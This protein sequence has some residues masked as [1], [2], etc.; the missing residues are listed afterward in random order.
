MESNTSVIV[1]MLADL[2]SVEPS[3]SD[4]SAAAKRNGHLSARVICLQKSF[5]W[6]TS[7][8]SPYASNCSN[9][10]AGSGL[11]NRKPWA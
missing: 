2:P 6:R 8:P 7:A 3:R 9:S 10:S 4:L 11:E 5:G 1:C